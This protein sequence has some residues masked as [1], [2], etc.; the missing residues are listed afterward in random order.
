MKI[1]IAT[2]NAGKIEGAK[3]AFA[4][5]YKNFEIIGVPVESDV[6]DEPVNDEICLGARNRIKNLKKYA[7]EN[8]IETDFYISIESGITNRLGDWIII[9][10]AMIED[11]NGLESLGTS[12]GFPVP[13][14]YVDEIIEKDLGKLMDRIFNQSELRKGKGGIS[15]LTHDVVT[16]YDLTEQAFIMCLTKYINNDIWR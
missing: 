5:Y 16:R 1:L 10:V 3:R 4:K 12:S 6:S 11:K 2:K 14:R 7:L 8:N 15:F 13:K 9:N